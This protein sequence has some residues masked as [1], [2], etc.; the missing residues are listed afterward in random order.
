[1]AGRELA[2]TSR[3]LKWEH[4]AAVEILLVLAVLI[5]RGL[6]YKPREHEAGWLVYPKKQTD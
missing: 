2:R 3:P 4:V 6:V 5:Y 1:M